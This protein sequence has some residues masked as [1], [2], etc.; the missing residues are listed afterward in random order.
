MPGGP[1]ADAQ[2]RSLEC[3]AGRSEATTAHL[4]FLPSVC[5]YSHRITFAPWLT[6]QLPKH[7]APLHFCCP[8]SHSHTSAPRSSHHN[9]NLLELD[10]TLEVWAGTCRD[11][12]APKG[13]NLVSCVQSCED[14]LGVTEWASSLERPSSR[15]FVNLIFARPLC[16]L[17][18]SC[19]TTKLR[20]NTQM[21]LY[22][23]E[24]H[25][26]R[27]VSTLGPD[28][29]HPWQP[30]IHDVETTK[31]MIHL[32][33]PLVLV[34]TMVPTGNAATWPGLIPL[35]ER[36]GLPHRSARSHVLLISFLLF[37]SLFLLPRARHNT[38]FKP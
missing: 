13:L 34:A 4:S 30:S 6:S 26:S 16:Y 25:T 21:T 8:A 12:G 35:V 11:T 9:R 19:L 23:F 5:T 36:N 29:H 2:R 15:I 20:H 14:R 27:A 37:L 1:S 38:P 7:I 17:M 31:N 32:V 24:S 10:R 28:L 22:A 3:S 33:A 18:A